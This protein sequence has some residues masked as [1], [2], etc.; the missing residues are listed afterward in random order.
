[1]ALALDAAFGDRL[2]VEDAAGSEACRLSGGAFVQDTICWAAAPG[3]RAI[4]LEAIGTTETAWLQNVTAVGTAGGTVGLDVNAS[5]AG[6]SAEL[7]GTNVIAEGGGVDIRAVSGPASEAG[8]ALGYSNFETTSAVGPGSVLFA[9]GAGT[10]QA[11]AP[12]FLDPLAGD[13]H[14]DT[15]SPTV[16]SGTSEV[17]FADR[18]IDGEDRKQGFWIDIGADEATVDPAAPDTNPPET[19][20]LKKPGR[21]TAGRRPKFRFGTSEPAGAVFHCSLDDRPFGVCDSPQRLKVRRGRKHTF[22]VYS[23]DEA[24]NADPTPAVHT[25]KVT[26]KHG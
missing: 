19:V 20:I 26:G 14:Q 25:W 15:E 22:R 5:G 9:P 8:I 17:A 24:G 12:V 13:F 16:D 18:D 10:N 21:R 7:Q 1:V 2:N 3:G 23:V 11:A 6:A 4:G